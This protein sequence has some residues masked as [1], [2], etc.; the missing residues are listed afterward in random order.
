M[1][2]LTD[3]LSSLL[4]L[5]NEIKDKVMRLEVA[6]NAILA[7]AKTYPCLAAPSMLSFASS[8]LWPVV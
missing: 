3:L 7:S 1:H 5:L 6:F 8:L 2:I 4:Y